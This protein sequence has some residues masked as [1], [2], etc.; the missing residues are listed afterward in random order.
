MPLA[1]YLE[2]YD[3]SLSPAELD[4][5]HELTD[6]VAH[7]LESG[8]APDLELRSLVVEIGRKIASP[9]RARESA[10]ELRLVDQ[11]GSLSNSDGRDPAE[12]SPLKGPAPPEQ[13]VPH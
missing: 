6:Q 12:C 3:P 1:K 10:P 5:L 13:D 2:A 9:R 4:A 11:V 7:S 8:L